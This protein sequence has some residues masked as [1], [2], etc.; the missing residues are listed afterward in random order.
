MSTNSIGPVDSTEIN[1]EKLDWS[2]LFR[3]ESFPTVWFGA[4]NRLDVQRKSIVSDAV[5]RRE[6]YVDSVGLWL[7]QLDAR[8]YCSG[9]L[10]HCNTKHRKSQYKSNVFFPILHWISLISRIRWFQLESVKRD[11]RV[12]KDF[13]FLLLTIGSL[14]KWLWLLTENK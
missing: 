5:V 9:L 3:L 4:G 7:K 2:S 1:S 8:G 10:N 6:R 12:L 11:W 14:V 13:L